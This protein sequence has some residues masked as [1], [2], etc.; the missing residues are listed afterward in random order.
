M[1]MVWRKLMN[2]KILIAGLILAVA[3]SGGVWYW[4]SSSQKAAAAKVQ[5]VTV[6]RGDI[7]TTVA[8]TGTIEPVNTV[9]ISS[10]ITA[11]IKE[12]KVKENEEVQAGQVLVV[13]K[14]D[15]LQARV[16]QAR[17]RLNNAL[18]R[19]Q[20]TQKIAAIGGASAE[21]LDNARMD[22]LIAKASYDEVMSELNETVIVSPI[23]GTIIGKP[24]AAGEM[25][26][27]GVNN[28][29]VIMTIADMSTMQISAKIDQTDIGKIREGQSVT[30]TVDAYPGKEFAGTVT[31]ISRQPTV[32]QNVTYYP[33]TISVANA[34]NLLFP[35]MVARVIVKVSESKGVL[36]LP[37]AAIQTDQKGKFVQVMGKN[38]ELQT[39]RITTGASGNG[40]ME[41]TSGLNEG[42]Q[43]A[44]NQP[45]SG[46]VSS[47]NRQGQ[48]APRLPRMF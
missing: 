28:P 46:T 7:V 8:A 14:D 2:K 29:T 3:V 12:V 42:D 35:G 23:A 5:L 40:R 11:Q 32:E 20:R 38:G 1:S 22:Y 10:K 18:I 44:I 26:A 37:L 21:E 6:E 34:E 30:F 15:D 24:M 9:E 19:Y 45:V 25:V 36:T 33:V 39:V 27:Q 13:L 48:Q 43:V 17:E 41:I 4:Q 16:T 31:T 47:N